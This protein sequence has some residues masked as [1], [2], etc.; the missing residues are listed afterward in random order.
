MTIQITRPSNAQAMNIYVL[1]WLEYSYVISALLC[2]TLN[3]QIL[4]S[5]GYECYKKHW[6][7]YSPFPENANMGEQPI[8]R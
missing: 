4:I 3:G 1:K 6:W 5:M 8:D 7:V 2:V